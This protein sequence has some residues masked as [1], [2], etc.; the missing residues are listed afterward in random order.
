MGRHNRREVSNTPETERQRER[1]LDKLRKELIKP[2]YTY[3]DNGNNKSSS[4]NY[5][6]KK[7]VKNHN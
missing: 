2:K 6:K 3:K 1:E 4:Q 7:F 5:K